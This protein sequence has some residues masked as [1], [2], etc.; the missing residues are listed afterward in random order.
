MTDT[1]RI[2]MGGTL[3]LLGATRG[4]DPFVCILGEAVGGQP[5]TWVEFS[6]SDFIAQAARV[7]GPVQ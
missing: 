6:T 4:D 7:M 5:R 3:R 1:T 2:L